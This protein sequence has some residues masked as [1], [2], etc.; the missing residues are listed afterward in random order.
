MGLWTATQFNACS[1]AVHFKTSTAELKQQLL[2]SAV[3]LINGDAQ[4]TNDTVVELT[5]QNNVANEV[6][7][8]N[9]PTCKSGGSWQ[10][11]QDK[12]PWTL[13]KSN[14]EVAVY[15][16]YRNIIEDLY[17]DCVKDTIV[18]D[19]Q[20]PSVNLNI[21]NLGTNIAVPNFQFV[22]YDALS[23]VKE[24]RCKWPGMSQY[25]VCM[26]SSSN[27]NLAEG[28]YNVQVVA[29][30]MAGNVGDPVIQELTVDR[31]PPVA[32]INRAPAAVTADPNAA[33]EFS[34]TDSLSGV[35]KLQCSKENL[36][37][38]VDCNS[39]YNWVVSEGQ[40]T[41]YVRALDNVGNISAVV[42]HAFN[43]DLTAPTVRILTG[44][45]DYSNSATAQFTFDG[46]DGST[47]ITI[48][49][50]RIDGGAYSSCSSP[51]SYS[52]LSNSLHNFE[53][54]GKDSAGLWSAPVS[55]KW[56]V[57]TVAP[58]VAFTQTPAAIT[59]S[60]A[61]AFRY[62]ITDSGTG[63]KGAECSLDGAAF[64]ACDTG[65]ADFSGLSAAAHEFRVRG[66]DQAGNVSAIAKYN[67][68]IDRTAP[69][70]TLTSGPAN[71]S[72]S[73]QAKFVYV[74]SDAGGSGIDR[75][76]CRLDAAAYAPC[77]SSS[78]HIQRDLVEG[79]R[80]EAIRAVDK[81]GNYS[82]EVV[83]VWNV[84]LTGPSIDYFQNPTDIMLSTSI[85]KLGF[86]VS[87]ING[88]TELT[89]KLNGQ[90]QACVS[91]QMIQFSNLAK[92]DYSFVVT[93]KDGAGNTTVDTKLFQVKDPVSKTQLFDVHENTK[94]DIVVI[95]DNSSSMADEMVEMG[96]HF[97]QFIGQ[98]DSNGLDWQL[99]II[100]TDVK[101]DGVK[102]DGRL[103]ELNGLPGQYII[104]SSMNSTLAD[105][106]FK[107]TIQMETN[108]SG[109]ELG[110]MAAKRAVERA[111]D[112]TPNSAPNAQLFRSD[113]TL[114][115]L[116]V[117]DAYDPS[118]TPKAFIDTVKAKMGAQKVFA[119]HSIV[120]PESSYTDPNASSI[121]SA[122]PCRKYRES[123]KFDG[124]T[125]HDLSEQTGGIKGSI[126]TSNY[127]SQLAAMGR[128]TVELVSAVTL[129]CQPV[130][131][132]ADGKV[133]KNDIQITLTGGA[134]YT[135]FNLSGNKIT[136]NSALP[137][138]SQSVRYY[139]LQ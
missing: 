72:N 7:V 135:D 13:S 1:Q 94:V 99:G 63:V 103:L 134:P 106:L 11:M 98:L 83:V 118:T 9:D 37:S 20:K 133:D 124:R 28:I 117:S 70:L 55:R 112:G 113:A 67:W 5:L 4:F 90:V 104:N 19:N 127:T 115:F 24:S 92:G 86:T 126:C 89:C 36:N 31:T 32:I 69:T 61:A 87:D 15:A 105:T 114:A 18:H 73:A 71:P 125:Y 81:A 79:Q 47:P 12:M 95:M 116:V 97:N 84:D 121:P 139:C 74:A 10:P 25:V 23:G 102:R 33:F 59:S 6:F 40:H 57:D 35:K 109:D 88:V 42:S 54:R 76:E 16:K 122:D 14:A 26:N 111:F 3:I 49:E 120:V 68:V 38:F 65:Q 93:A 137:A 8:T 130:D 29:E 46:M 60:Q 44:P 77:D 108:G 85:Q 17:T 78:Q 2:S 107:N 129:D 22:A 39:P 34:A 136:F 66:I 128:K 138:G 56:T 62:S 82:N 52:G 110:I 64:A 132:N 96:N 123:I 48:F 50:C 80:R 53:V 41:I 91:G 51:K 43:V 75:V 45:D 131:S 58:V 119:F 101:K 21:P 30:D 100:T 27:G